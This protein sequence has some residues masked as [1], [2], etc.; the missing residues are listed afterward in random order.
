[1]GPTAEEGDVADTAAAS[2]PMA[3][4]PP[5]QAT[6]RTNQSLGASNRFTALPTL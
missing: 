5:S 1:M 4:S 6:H 3:G 2:P